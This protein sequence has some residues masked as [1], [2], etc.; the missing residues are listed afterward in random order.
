MIYL[1]VQFSKG[2]HSVPIALLCR[3]REPDHRLD[4]VL[5]YRPAVTIQL[6]EG[7][8]GIVQPS[9]RRMGQPDNRLIDS[10]R[11]GGGICKDVLCH[12]ILRM[13]IFQFGS[14]LQPLQGSALIPLCPYAV[15][16]HPADAVLE[17]VIG[18]LICQRPEA[19]I[20][21][22][23]IPGGLAV[24]CGAAN[25]VMIPFSQLPCGIG[26]TLCRGKGIQ[27]QR[28]FIIL[29]HPSALAVQ[30]GKGVLRILVLLFSRFGK[31]LCGRFIV[32]LRPKPASAHFP[33]AVL[34]IAAGVLPLH[35]LEG[36]ERLG[37]PRMRLLRVNAHASAVRKHSA[38]VVHG[39]GVAAE[40]LHHE[41][42]AGL[43]VI[44][45]RIVI[46]K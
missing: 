36:R 21:H 7:V 34:H 31:P 6:A 24:I 27:L 37:V 17:P 30:S 45:G 15:Q 16:E 14:F 25:A 46:P 40:G 3:L 39:E 28:H 23:E 26:N 44:L 35:G 33:D 12:L 20:G 19:L 1:Q 2:V 18:A 41:E 10:A 22:G 8:L 11:C 13:R 42:A 9:F 4:R 43:L 5:H 32:L 29:R 38:Q